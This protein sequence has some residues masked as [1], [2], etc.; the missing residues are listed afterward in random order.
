MEI[1]FHGHNILC[2]LYVANP[3]ISSYNNQGARSKLAAMYRCQS[4]K[5]IIQL[6]ELYSPTK[7]DAT[8]CPYC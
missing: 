6:V 3:K 5:V 7:R 4:C 2:P 1:F 8:H